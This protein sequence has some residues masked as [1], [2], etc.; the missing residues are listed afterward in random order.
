[1]SSRITGSLRVGVKRDGA[2]FTRFT[3]DAR[4]RMRATKQGGSSKPILFLDIDG[5]LNET[6][7]AKQ[8]AL[9]E[10]KVALLGS[11]IDRS[12]AD[13]VLTTYWRYFEEYIGYTFERHG[14]RS[15]AKRET[16]GRARARLMDVSCE[17]DER[18]FRTRCFRRFT[19]GL[20]DWTNCR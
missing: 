3:R 12:G 14:E 20:R 4:T 6:A 10:V 16:D 1:M 11:V 8:I 18:E 7:T 13:I 2:R 19:P 15:K 17:T 9:D 5:V